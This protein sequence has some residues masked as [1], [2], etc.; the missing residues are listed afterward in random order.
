MTTLTIDLDEATLSACF[1][2]L[3]AYGVVDKTGATPE[4]ILPAAIRVFLGKRPTK[5]PE[6]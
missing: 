1:I 5:D 2:R 3:R 6:R 4:D